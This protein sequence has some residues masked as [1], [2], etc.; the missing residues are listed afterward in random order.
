MCFL[1]YEGCVFS[2][3]VDGASFGEWSACDFNSR[4]VRRRGSRFCSEAHVC[5]QLSDFVASWT[6]VTSSRDFAA[7][8]HIVH[9]MHC[10][11]PA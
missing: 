11:I 1:W 5:L 7:Y 8:L 10:D 6:S 2:H 9:A 4:G 3:K